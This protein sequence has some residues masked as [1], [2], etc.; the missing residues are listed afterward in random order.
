MEKIQVT[1]RDHETLRQEV[2]NGSSA[3]LVSIF[4]Q[5]ENAR[6][7]VSITIEQAEKLLEMLNRESHLSMT[8]TIDYEQSQGLRY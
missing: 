2:E 7:I 6:D 4:M 5:F 1:A 3:G 8:I